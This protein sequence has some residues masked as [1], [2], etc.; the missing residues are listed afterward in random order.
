[1]TQPTNP[2]PGE[3]LIVHIDP[4]LADIV[5]GFLENRRKDIVV[6][7]TA[8][9]CGDFETVRMLGHRLKGDGG[10]YGFDAISEIG[11]AIEHAAVRHDIPTLKQKTHALEDYLNRVDVVYR[12]D[13]G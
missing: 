1:M 10:G 6:M 7:Q 9:P 4:D 3:K 12:K 2:A 13:N 8:I 11:A 5:P